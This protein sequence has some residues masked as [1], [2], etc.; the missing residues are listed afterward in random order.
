MQRRE[1]EDQQMFPFPR[2]TF[3]SVANCNP[4]WPSDRV[5]LIDG[6]ATTTTTATGNGTLPVSL[7]RSS[8]VRP[9]TAMIYSNEAEAPSPLPN[10]SWVMQR[11]LSRGGGPLSTMTIRDFFCRQCHD[12][13]LAEKSWVLVV[14]R[15]EC[16]WMAW[17][18]EGGTHD[19]SEANYYYYY[20][21]WTCWSLILRRMNRI[22][23]N[24]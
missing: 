9:P 18:Q 21:S 3:A 16:R 6:D 13:S 17:Q 11:N 2:S 1:I 23:L 4:H 8:S 20:Y 12:V 7:P 22:N 15:F 5:A 10:P 24:S 14:V 19:E